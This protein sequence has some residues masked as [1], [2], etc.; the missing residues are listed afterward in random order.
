MSALLTRKPH[1]SAVCLDPA[2]WFDRRTAI[3]AD[4]HAR[5]I[6]DRHEHIVATRMSG[7]AGIAEC[8]VAV[9]GIAL[10]AHG[11]GWLVA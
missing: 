4:T 2:L 11:C 1:R 10:G 5:R 3:T 6:D 8:A 7:G 9:G